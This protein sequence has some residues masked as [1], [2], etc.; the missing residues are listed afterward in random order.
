MTRRRD[1]RLRSRCPQLDA[2]FERQR[3]R[4]RRRLG[5]ESVAV[6]HDDA[7]EGLGRMGSP[8]SEPWNTFTNRK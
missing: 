2:F 3:S 5:L 6:R 7:D 4:I 8:L 1:S